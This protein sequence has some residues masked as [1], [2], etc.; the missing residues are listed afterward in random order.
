MATIAVHNG[1][2][3]SQGHNRRDYIEDHIDADGVHEVWKDIPIVQAYNDLF[4][5]ALNDYNSRQTREDRKIASYYQ[6]VKRSKTLH[7]GYELVIGV[8]G[9]EVSN[10]DRYDILRKFYSTWEERNPT[11]ACIGAY[12]HADEE[13]APHLHLDYVPVAHSSRGLRTQTSL[14]KALKEMGLVTSKGKSTAQVQMEQQNRDY[15]EE[16]C[17]EHGIEVAHTTGEQKKEHVDTLTYKAQRD[18]ET[19]Q[20]AVERCE[21][22]LTDLEKQ[23]VVATENLERVH[24][25]ES[26]IVRASDSYEAIRAHRDRDTVA[27][28]TAFAEARTVPIGRHRGQKQVTMDE[29]MYERLQALIARSAMYEKAYEAVKGLGS[30]IQAI[31]SQAREYY[32]KARKALDEAETARREADEIISRRRYNVE[33]Q[34][35]DRLQTDAE[36]MSHR[37]DALKQQHDALMSDVADLENT[38]DKAELSRYERQYLDRH[39]AE[40][41]RFVDAQKERDR[42]G[43][44]RER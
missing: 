8:Y 30:R 1:H 34:K 25:L 31:L 22:Q 10:E 20:K 4:G 16:L 32:Q 17:R 21:M 37:V 2:S 42:W 28:E 14:K 9:D 15:L 26:E 44:D 36:I 5:E 7:T 23:A 13:G 33:K 41:Q 35:L 19:A 24:E 3:F 29:S 39:K 43:Y 12:Y 40:F 18:L 27:L 6:H 38:R 11:L